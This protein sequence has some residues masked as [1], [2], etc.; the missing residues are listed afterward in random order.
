MI[1]TER[2]RPWHWLLPVLS[3]VFAW[4][5]GSVYQAIRSA[6]L[7]S[8]A[9]VD[10]QSDGENISLN[11][12]T[13]EVTEPCGCVAGRI[14]RSEA[15]KLDVASKPLDPKERAR[16]LLAVG[17]AALLRSTSRSR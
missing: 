10:Y 11:W 5:A 12:R 17:E 13:L 3:V 9:W 1:G 16:I 7:D 6:R 2:R 14:S 4:G 15:R 8:L